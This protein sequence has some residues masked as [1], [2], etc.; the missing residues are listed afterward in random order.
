MI[1]VTANAACSIALRNAILKGV[2][3][4]FWE[5]M[6]AKARKV[7]AGDVTTLSAKR[8]EAISR[9][10]HF[11][12]TEAQVL[13]RLG[14]EGVADIGV[15]DLVTL[16]GLFTA[17]QDGDTSPEQAFAAEPGDRSVTPQG[18]SEER[19]AERLPIMKEQL[20]KGK[21][22]AAV[23]QFYRARGMTEE[24]AQRFSAEVAP[25]PT[26]GAAS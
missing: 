9:F 20:T 19:Y 26:T 3:K 23:L 1:G 18:W 13:A 7:I 17:I 16:F 6:Y 10:A 8:A 2:P 14:R 24:Q 5:P 11:G 22:L 25:A 21:P 15:D 4:A 12:I